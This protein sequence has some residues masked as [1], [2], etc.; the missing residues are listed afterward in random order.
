MTGKVVSAALVVLV[1]FGCSD[2][3]TTPTA[4]SGPL[5]FQAGSG[6]DEA[7]LF[8]GNFTPGDPGN[9]VLRIEATSG[10]VVD[11]M[12]PEGSGGLTIACCMTFDVMRIATDWLG[13]ARRNANASASATAG[14]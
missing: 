7:A 12:V 1:A 5:L 2:P 8:A 4:A 10:A 13:L 11:L 6:A 14:S 9:G 3:P